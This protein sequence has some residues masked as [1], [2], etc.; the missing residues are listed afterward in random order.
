MREA[1]HEVGGVR[2]SGRD[3]TSGRFT[4]LLE[5]ALGVATSC[6]FGIWSVKKGTNLV[7]RRPTEVGARGCP[8]RRGLVRLVRL[9]APSQRD[10]PRRG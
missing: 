9:Q 7:G 8:R 4:H 1:D 2:S 10:E 3:E 6:T 5:G